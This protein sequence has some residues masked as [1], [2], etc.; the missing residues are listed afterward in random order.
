MS[1]EITYPFPDFN[2]AA[3]EVSKWISNFIPQFTVLMIT[4]PGWDW[5][6]SSLEALDDVIQMGR[7]NLANYRITFS[8]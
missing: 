6:W 4:Y 3:A 8:V 1:N 7:Q 5:R 2:G